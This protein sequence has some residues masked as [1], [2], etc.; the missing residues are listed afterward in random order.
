MPPVFI[1]VMRDLIANARKYTAP[2]GRINAGIWSSAN[3][4]VLSV[5][6]SGCGIPANE[7]ER[8]IGF[9][10]RGSNVTEQRTMGAGIG[11]TKAYYLTKKMQGRMWISSEEGQSTRVKIT[12]PR[13]N[14]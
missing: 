5:E 1:D 14:S 7:I 8:V 6:D 2:G 3:E 4:L 11:L 13:H 12:L 9:G 10:R